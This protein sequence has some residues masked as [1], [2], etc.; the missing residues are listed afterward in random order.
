MVY[1]VILQAALWVKSMNLRRLAVL[2]SVLSIIL[3]I[4]YCSLNFSI[5]LFEKT[6]CILKLKYRVS[7]KKW[8]K[9]L[10]TILVVWQLSGFCLAHMI[11]CD[12]HIQ[13][14]GLLL[15]CISKWPRRETIECT[16]SFGTQIEWCSKLCRSR[17][18]V[19]GIKKRMDYCKGV[20]RCAGSGRKTVVPRMTF[21]K[22]SL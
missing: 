22:L 20:D 19:D 18:T 21:R 9:L 8:T 3:L 4:Y 11:L 6:N 10:V 13:E 12:C 14:K 1:P 7:Q 5:W 15:M 17:T 2:T 16:S